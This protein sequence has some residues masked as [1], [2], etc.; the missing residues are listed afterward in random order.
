M[1]DCTDMWT[2][3][4]QYMVVLLCGRSWFGVHPCFPI[5]HSGADSDRGL[6]ASKEGGGVDKD[7]MLPPSS[8]AR[9]AM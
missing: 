7:A 2:A 5:L 3:R 1:V 9:M 4:M 8:F 6:D